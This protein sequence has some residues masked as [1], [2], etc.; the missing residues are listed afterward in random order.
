MCENSIYI[1][2][3]NIP[4]YCDTLTLGLLA[5]PAGQTKWTNTASS[6]KVTGGVVEAVEV[7][8]GWKEA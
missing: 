5:I 1:S 3:T 6:V 8:A 7:S 4:V 2:C